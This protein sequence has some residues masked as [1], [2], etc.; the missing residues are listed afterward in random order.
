MSGKISAQ[1]NT[2]QLMTTETLPLGKTDIQLSPIGLGA[3]QWGDR[4]FWSSGTQYTAE[5]CRAAFSASLAAGVNWVDTAELYGPGT[6]EIMLGQFLRERPANILIAS[7]CFPYP[8]RWS[9]KTLHG[10][11]RGS[12]K[13]LGVERIDLYQMHQPHGP[14]AVESWMD[15]MAEAVKDGLI[16]A[17]GVSNYSAEQTRRAHERLTK[18]GLSLASNQIRYNLLQR[19]PERNGVLETCHELGVT[20]IAYS[21]IA[22]GI[23]SGKYTPENAPPGLRGARYNR[24]HLRR[25]Q[26]LI[27]LMKE[28]G[29]AHAN[30][31]PTQVALNWLIGKGMAPIPGAKNA[32]QA[33]ENASAMGW[34]LTGDEVKALEAASD[35]VQ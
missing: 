3:W 5:D 35:K 28:I 20:V 27:E 14:L 9:G 30:K 12:L 34:R 18:H 22:Q 15:A 13:R 16:R 29:Q 26:P 32:R 31:T 7:K 24:D 6:S 8:W 17:I 19:L 23:L 11:L 25:V 4:F 1:S 21:P 10:A 33:Q 2:E